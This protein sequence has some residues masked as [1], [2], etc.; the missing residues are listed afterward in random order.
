[1]AIKFKIAEEDY[2]FVKKIADDNDLDLQDT[3]DAMYEYFTDTKDES[4]VFGKETWS[5][6]NEVEVK[7]TYY[8]I[9]EWE[10]EYQLKSHIIFTYITECIFNEIEDFKKMFEL[11]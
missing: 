7:T 11:I 6:K 1:M 3:I 9:I 4:K 5:C 8:R 2:K 10:E